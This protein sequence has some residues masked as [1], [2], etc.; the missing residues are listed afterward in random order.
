M[1]KRK[2]KQNLKLSTIEG[3]FWAIMYGGGETFLSACAVFLQFSPFQ[4][5]FLSSFPPFVGSCFQLFSASIKNKFKDIKQF[6][7]TMSYLQ[8][9]LWVVL[10]LLL[11][12]KPTYKYILIWSCIYWTI[13]TVI[14]PAWTAWMGYFVPRRIRARYFGK[15]NRIIG[16]VSFI[17]TLIAGYILDIFDQNMT[18]GFG[19]IFIAAFLGRTFSAFYLNK[20]FNFEEKE[21]KNLIEYIYSFKNLINE[22]NKSFYYIL[23]NSYISFSIM[24]FG[25]LFSI[26]MLRT[27]ELSVFIYTINMTLWQISNF[28]SSNYFGT[29]CQKIGDYKVL[30]LS[31]YTIV[32]LP[33]LWILLYYLD[34]QT[35]IIATFLVSILA[36]I[37]FS[38]YTLSSFN[39]LYKISKKE[40]V[41]HFSALGTFIRGV[42]ILLGGILAGLLVESKFIFEFAENFNLIPIHISMMIS[43]LLRFLSI[44]I[45]KKLNNY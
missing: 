22:Q 12:Y 37:C 4:I 7:V 6:V 17:A 29:L 31:T 15:R 19:I 33:I 1:E 39:L 38:A 16:F 24:F 23:F 32:F 43:V 13:G 18:Y 20:K 9:L 40:D 35:Q 10:V 14:Q 30:R 11:F 45:L 26:Y 28:S 25:P 34:N 41:I 5:S 2:V 27:M 3:S 44:P 42:A 8:A 21:S 36:G